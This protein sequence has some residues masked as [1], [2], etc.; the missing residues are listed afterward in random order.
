[1][2]FFLIL[3]ILKFE[4]YCR[5]IFFECLIYYELYYQIFSY[6]DCK[7]RDLFFS[8]F[9]RVELLDEIIIEWSD[10]ID[11]NNQGIQVS[12]LCVFC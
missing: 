10:V 6:L 5:K 8:F 7:I 11:I 3:D 12:E 1:M 2:F 9:L 4:V